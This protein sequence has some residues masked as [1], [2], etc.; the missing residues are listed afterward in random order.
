MMMFLKAVRKKKKRAWPQRMVCVGKSQPA[1][2]VV[3]RAAR[4]V[5]RQI[6]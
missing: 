2:V 3:G 1:M 4:G 5:L 6:P